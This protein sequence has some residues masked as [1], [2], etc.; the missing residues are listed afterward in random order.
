MAG[1]QKYRMQ[2]DP[3][4]DSLETVT[5]NDFGYNNLNLLLNLSFQPWDHIAFV[6]A[7]PANGGCDFDD[8]QSHYA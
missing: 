7:G 5:A 1:F 4:P 8:S 3:L 6:L 2:T